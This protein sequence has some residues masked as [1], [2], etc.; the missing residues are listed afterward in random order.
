M[1]LPFVIL[2]FIV[3]CNKQFIFT[4]LC[5]ILFCFLF[6]QIPTATPS[7]NLPKIEEN[8]TFSAFTRFVCNYI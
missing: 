1:E 8:F 3:F 5:D 6:I 4:E 7:I 2:S